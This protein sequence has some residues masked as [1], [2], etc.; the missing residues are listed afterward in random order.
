MIFRMNVVVE[1]FHLLLYEGCSGGSLSMKIFQ[2]LG[3]GLRPY[4]LIWLSQPTKIA[5]LFWGVA[6]P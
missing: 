4:C 1:M 3:L 6:N 2:F 5:P